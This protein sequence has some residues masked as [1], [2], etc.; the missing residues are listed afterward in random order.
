MA[1]DRIG[2][3]GG[4]F[5]PVH[6]GHLALARRALDAVRL[7]RVLFVPAADSPFKI[8]RMHAPAADREAMLR[9][10]CERKGIEPDAL[11]AFDYAAYKEQQYDL[12][13]DA[14]R[15]GFDMELIY[16]ILEEGITDGTEI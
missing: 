6:A 11:T 1:G 5:D 3:F 7:D 8:G 12:L 14:V 2:V 10:L 13:A 15:K 4:S 9:L 16:R